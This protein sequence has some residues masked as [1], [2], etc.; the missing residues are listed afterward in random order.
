MTLASDQQLQVAASPLG[1]AAEPGVRGDGTT[2]AGRA[3]G[4][5]R[6]WRWPL[7]FAAG[8][9]VTAVIAALAVPRTG[10]GRL[11]PDS[12]EPQGARAVAQ[13]LER[14]G[15]QV[16]AV[17][18]TSGAVEAA[19]AGSTLLVA[20]T[21]VLSPD[22]L[23]ALAGA[24]ADLVLVE[25]DALTLSRLAP[26]LEPAGVADAVVTDP[27]CDQPD[28]QAAGAVL[29]GGRLVRATAPG[30]VVCYP[31]AEEDGGAFAVT[32]ADGRRVT[33]LGQSQVLTN[34]DIDQEGNA[35]LALRTLGRHDRLT[36]YLAV[37]ELP[38]AAEANLLDLLPPWVLWSLYQLLVVL[39]FVVAWRARRLGRL[40][41][42]PLP[43]VVRAGE[44]TEGRARMYRRSR[45]TGRAAATLR[46]AAL[47]R[48]AGRLGL[49]RSA[50]AAEVA[51]A[52][53]RAAARDPAQVTTLLLGAAPT[54]DRALTRLADDLD[55][56][57]KEVRRP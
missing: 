38:P 3:A 14:L 10:V 4:W 39:A 23:D 6:R 33:V 31:A 12:A 20:R 11:H 56:L 8:I 55:T 5:W 13:V 47:R 42:E 25:P 27:G 41:P 52:A 16:Q 29:G 45:S 54:D 19:T 15:V 7:L 35:A 57:E 24:A 34:A 40:V 46:A 48:L 22:Q 51:E 21:E 2:G 32:Q 50:T 53:A 1:T 44:T 18:S 28:A 9:L 49:S 30:P 37:P 26:D 17:R 43:V 36:W